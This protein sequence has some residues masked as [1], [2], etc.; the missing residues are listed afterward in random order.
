M[1]NLRLYT[2]LCIM[3]VICVSAYAQNDSQN[4]DDAVQAIKVKGLNARKANLQRQ[5]KIEDQKRNQTLNG[6]TAETQ[7]ILN[8]KQDSICLELRS[9]LVSVELELKELVPDETASVIANQLNILQ[10]QQQSGEE[11]ATGNDK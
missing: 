1:K 10:N 11:T 9:Q 4:K 8:E 3:A 6:V 2:L 7:E 5:I